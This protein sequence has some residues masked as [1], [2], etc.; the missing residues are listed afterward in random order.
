MV[1]NNIQI[2]PQ[3]FEIYQKWQTSCLSYRQKMMMINAI[4]PNNR[5]SD[6]KDSTT[7]YASAGQWGWACYLVQK[8]LTSYWWLLSWRSPEARGSHVAWTLVVACSNWKVVTTKSWTELYGYCYCS[9]AYYCML[10][11]NV[12]KTITGK[13]WNSVDKVIIW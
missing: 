13:Q 12:I 7:K 8:S 5:T 3:F 11:N 1:C 9:I 6:G 2:R 10:L 4:P